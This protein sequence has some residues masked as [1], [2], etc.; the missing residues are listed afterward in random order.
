MEFLVFMELQKTKKRS[1]ELEIIKSPIIIFQLWL[2]KYGGYFDFLNVC[3]S[4]RKINKI[5]NLITWMGNNVYQFQLIEQSTTL[6]KWRI[7]G[8]VLNKIRD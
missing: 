6:N 2:Y 8:T 5:A 4:I 3:G 7:I 1:K